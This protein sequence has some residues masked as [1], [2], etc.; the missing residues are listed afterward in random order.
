MAD[1]IESKKQQVIDTAREQVDAGAHYLWSTAGNTPGNKDGAWYRPLKA[2]LH[3]NLPDLDSLGQ[4]PNRGSVKV[5]RPRSNVVRGLR[6]YVRLRPPGLRRPGWR[7][8]RSVSF[9]GHEFEHRKSARFEM[10]KSYR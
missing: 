3:P 6:G 9:G 7:G 4:D 2:Q 8:H 1:E 5:Q 10:E